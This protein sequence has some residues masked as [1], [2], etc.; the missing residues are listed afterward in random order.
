M[1]MCQVVKV[2]WSF[3]GKVLLLPW[4]IIIRQDSTGAIALGHCHR[5]L[6]L[7]L[8]QPS[9]SW[10]RGLDR[11]TCSLKVPWGPSSLDRTCFAPVASSE[12]LGQRADTNNSWCLFG[13][14][15]NFFLI[16]WQ[17]LNI[18]WIHSQIQISL[19]EN[20]GDLV[21]LGWHS[22]LGSMSVPPAS[23]PFFPFSHFLAWPP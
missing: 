5:S 1:P 17:H 18:G 3:Y 10:G 14:Q 19:L 15:L 23:V 12:K 2:Q 7:E 6:V 16:S 13:L 9:L 11:N 4:G 21:A 22:H 8:R 20:L